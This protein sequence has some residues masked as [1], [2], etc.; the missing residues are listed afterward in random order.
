MKNFFA[1]FWIDVIYLISVG[2]IAVY[3]VLFS[4]FNS[5]NS[6]LS[7]TYPYQ[8]PVSGNYSLDYRMYKLFFGVG[9]VLMLINIWYF[10]SSFKNKNNKAVLN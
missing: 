10:I 4:I 3:T 8:Y 9:I 2:M 7:G 6:R 1:I 5:I